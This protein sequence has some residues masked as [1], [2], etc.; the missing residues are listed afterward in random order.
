MKRKTNFSFSKFYRN[1]RRI[2]V[3][4][5]EI[6]KC[7]NCGYEFRGHFCP[8]CGQ[9]VAE[10]NRP[11]GFV[12]YDFMGNFF[13]FD[14]RFFKTFK[15]LLFFPG[16]L[17]KEFFK[18]RRTSYSPPFRIFVFLSFVLFLLLSFIT[19][20]GLKT[21]LDLNLPDSLKI[22]ED[23]IPITNEQRLQIEKYAGTSLQDSTVKIETENLNIDLGGIFF[24]KGSIR[25]RLNQLADT[26]EIARVQ[27]T[28]PEEK[29]RIQEYIAMC[30]APEIVISTLLKYLSWASF[31]LLPIFALVLKL[32]YV[33]RKQ[34]YIRHLIFSI[35]L[36]SFLFMILIPVTFFRLIFNSVP[37]FINLILIGSFPIYFLFA[38]HSFYG[39]NWMKTF[40]KF[41]GMGVVYNCTLL[42]VVLLAFLKSIHIF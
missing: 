23:I 17:T 32:F 14:T 26:L 18:G 24:G 1:R 11:F 35:H 37:E 42:T 34:L 40:L 27:A 20:K 39:Q 7:Q 13:S 36:H 4:E 9:E 3:E 5:L 16:F 38:L 10:F 41:I 28:D 25:A 31:L 33:R 15:Y 22:S 21:E 12:I 8:D 2:P 6:G 29:Q 30:R 19:D